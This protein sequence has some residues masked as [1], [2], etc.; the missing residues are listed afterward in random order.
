MT[1]ND[2]LERQQRTVLS[3]GALLGL[4]RLGIF[5]L[6]QFRWRGCF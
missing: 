2:E 4:K 1:R 6:L 5:M 3:N